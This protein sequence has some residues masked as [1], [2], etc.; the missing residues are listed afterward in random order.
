[1]SVFRRRLVFRTDRETRLLGSLSIVNATTVVAAIVFAGAAAGNTSATTGD[2][3]GSIVFAGAP[4]SEVSIE[5]SGAGSVVLAGPAT[6][7]QRNFGFA[8][9][10]LAFAGTARC[11]ATGSGAITFSGS[12]TVGSVFTMDASGAVV[13]AGTSNAGSI[14]VASVAAPIV[15][16]GTVGAPEISGGTVSGTAS[17]EMLFSGV[18][19]A[20][21]IDSALGVVEFSGSATGSGSAIVGRYKCELRRSVTVEV[22]R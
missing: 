11:D 12:A 18:A 1:M 7:V 5:V 8:V 4:V 9:G 15:F 3:T 19:D 2:A 21:Q 22:Q 14:S 10:T 16:A 17:G 13:F 6:G 20:V